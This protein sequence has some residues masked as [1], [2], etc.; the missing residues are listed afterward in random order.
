MQMLYAVDFDVASRDGRD[1]QV[2]YHA[3]FEHLFEWLS[4]GATGHPSRESLLSNGSLEYMKH[5][6][7]GQ[8]DTLRRADWLL[9]GSGELNAFRIDVRQP[10]AAKGTWFQTRITL[11]RDQNRCRLRVVMGRDITSGWLAPVP[12]DTLRRPAL[13]KNVTRDLRLDV[14]VSNQSVDN[15]FALIKDPTTIPVL[16]EALGNSNRLPILA[17][18][19]LG[20]AG[21]S[22][23]G[24][25]ARELQGLASVVSLSPRMVELI[26]PDLAANSIPRGGARLFWPDLSLRQPLFSALQVENLSVD[27]NVEKLMRIL[28]PIS[29]IARSRDY[30]WENAVRADREAA[31][32]VVDAKIENARAIG[33]RQGEIQVLLETRERLQNDL[34]D[35]V[36]AYAELEEENAQL[37]SAVSQY[38]TVAWEAGHYKDLYYKSQ[39]GRNPS[40]LDWDSAPQCD[41]GEIVELLQFIADLSGGAFVY[42]DNAPKAWGKAEYPYPSRMRDALV[43]LGRAAVEYRQKSAKIDGRIVDWFRDAYGLKVSVID[44]GLELA[45]LDTFAYDDRTYS[46]IPHVKLD[47]NTTPDRVGRVY[48]A[49]DAEEKR[50]IIDHVGLKLYGL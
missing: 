3:L 37:K 30:G 45:K 29:V 5:G 47:D 34:S 46:R 7:E 49:K 9:A 1:L 14:R 48:F 11:S 28:A 41:D 27:L 22:L 20:D 36:D 26:N 25:C 16:L 18:A 38:D 32:S 44:R 12:F 21:R 35:W 24:A 17:I 13:V 8:E 4:W 40:S 2:V 15:R 23:A 10:L 50:L 43:A 6:L 33:D 39:G 42:S 19:P 31:T